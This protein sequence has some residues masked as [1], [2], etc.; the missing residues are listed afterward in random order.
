MFFLKIITKGNQKFKSQWYLYATS[1]EIFLQTNKQEI[2]KK[3]KKSECFYQSLHR[4]TS[5]TLRKD[6]FNNI[7][8]KVFKNRPS[9]F[10]E[11]SL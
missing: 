11:D 9:K 1:P 6:F 10:V 3:K 8:V 5:E 4:E 7:W 2:I